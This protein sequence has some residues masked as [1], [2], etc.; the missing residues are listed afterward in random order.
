MKSVSAIIR[1]SIDPAWG[2]A[3][4]RAVEALARHA[5]EHEAWL[6]PRL[7]AERAAGEARYQA[8]LIAEARDILAGSSQAQP[9]VAHLW[10]LLERLDCYEGPAVELPE[11]PF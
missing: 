2:S 11:R 6:D 5:E 7:E 1:E 9:Q 10:A 3:G 8:G 4:V